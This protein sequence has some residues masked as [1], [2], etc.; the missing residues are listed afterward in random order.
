MPE[1]PGLNRRQWEQKLAAIGEY[2]REHDA[3]A[4]LEIIGA[5]PVME[6]GLEGRT[7]LDLDVW[8]PA[9]EID[10]SALAAACIV[11]GL[12]F[13]PS[14][15]TDRPYL[16]LVQ[17]GIVAMPDHVPVKAGRWGALTVLTPPPAALAAMKLVRAEPKDIADVFFLCSRHG[18][19]REHV[20]E[21]V[22]R[23]P[24]PQKRRTAEE[25]LVYLDVPSAEE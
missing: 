15:E 13:D 1:G 14:A 5:W 16:Q 7:S 4:T 25:N 24:D 10:R 22:R 2:L 8:M 11:A 23:I 12:D 18:I 19:T 20:A 17:P 21:Y 9:S 3:P 6:A